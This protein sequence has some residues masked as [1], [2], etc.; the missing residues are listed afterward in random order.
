MRIVP[1]QSLRMQGWAAVVLVGLLGGCSTIENVVGPIGNVGLGDI[2][3]QGPATVDPNNPNPNQTTQVNADEDCPGALVRQGA[4]AWA[5]NDG[6]GPA[7]VR[8]QA[9]VIQIAR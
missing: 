5:Q 2:F 7:N 9:S 3:K 6:Q 8:Y 1:G 4:S